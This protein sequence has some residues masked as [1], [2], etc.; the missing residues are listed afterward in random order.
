MGKPFENIVG[1][2][3]NAGKLHFLHSPQCFQKAFTSRTSKVIIVVSV[4]DPGKLPVQ[5][6][7]YSNRA[8]IPITKGKSINSA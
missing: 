7:K 3:E 8:A 5:N 4:K 2:R 1:E 6:V